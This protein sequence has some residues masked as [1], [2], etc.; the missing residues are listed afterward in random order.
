MRTWCYN[1]M[2][3]HIKIINIICNHW[4]CVISADSLLEWVLCV[5]IEGEAD[6]A[7]QV[8]ATTAMLLWWHGIQTTGWDGPG[9]SGSS[10]P[11]H[12]ALHSGWWLL[13]SASHRGC[14]ALGA[15]AEMATHENPPWSV[16]KMKSDTSWNHT[17]IITTA[18]AASMD[19]GLWPLSS[20]SGIDGLGIPSSFAALVDAG[21]WSPTVCG[22]TVLTLAPEIIRCINVVNE[23]LLNKG[24]FTKCPQTKQLVPCKS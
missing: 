6:V 5:P 16:Y 15:Q 20:C 23:K 10:S 17:V 4:P 3:A 2:N 9:H 21:M 22:G 1:G 12:L 18:V 13:Q 24:R 8:N 7:M 11:W 19:G 14:H